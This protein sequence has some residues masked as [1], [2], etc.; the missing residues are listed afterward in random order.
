VGP[1]DI[2]GCSQAAQEEFLASFEG[3]DFSLPP[4]L[5]GAFVSH[6]LDDLSGVQTNAVP[7]GERN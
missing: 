4:R 6:A 5:A 3:T 7:A 1:G 2:F